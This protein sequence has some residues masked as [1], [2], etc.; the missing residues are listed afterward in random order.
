MKSDKKKIFKKMG[1]RQNYWIVCPLHWGATIVV[2]IAKESA[3][4]MLMEK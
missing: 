2:R 3:E 1:Q 4:Y